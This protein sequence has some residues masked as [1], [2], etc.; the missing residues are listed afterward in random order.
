[1]WLQGQEQGPKGQKLLEDR[2]R[3]HIRETIMLVR[4]P[5]DEVFHSSELPIPGG[6]QA[7]AG[8]SPLRGTEVGFE[9]VTNGLLMSP[10]KPRF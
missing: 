7:E 6:R 4:G 3:P 5:G 10:P 1:M 9:E 2:F 8:C